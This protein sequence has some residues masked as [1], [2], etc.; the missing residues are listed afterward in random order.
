MFSEEVKVRGNVI[1]GQIT[2]NWS[3]KSYFA[4]KL[5]EI[6]NSSMT[7]GEE[8]L[9]ELIAE[10]TEIRD[11]I[12]EMNEDYMCSVCNEVKDEL[13][14]CESCN[15]NVCSNCCVDITYHNQI[16]FPYCKL[17]EEISSALD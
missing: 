6:S 3:K 10:L 15:N 17:C 9:N 11:K 1:K 12:E 14:R 4:F 16:D 13:V 2:G 7:F 8:D 5:K